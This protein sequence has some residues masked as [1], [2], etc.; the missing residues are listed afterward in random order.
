MKTKRYNAIKKFYVTDEKIPQ[1]LGC[2]D[3][4]EKYYNKIVSLPEENVEFPLIDIYESNSNAEK[5]FPQY[6]STVSTYH[7]LETIVIDDIV[8]IYDF[9]TYFMPLIIRFES[10]YYI[11][12]MDSE[13]KIRKEWIDKNLE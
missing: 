8:S 4:I 7:S 6:F 12:K 1:D 13:F 5:D 2:S 3:F 11:K 10:K 9:L